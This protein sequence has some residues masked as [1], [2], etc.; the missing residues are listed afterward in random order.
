MNQNSMGENFLNIDYPTLKYQCRTKED[1]VE[2]PFPPWWGKDRMGGAYS[3][4]HG[5][6]YD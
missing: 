2:S 3:A 5:V 4:D 6:V 1:D